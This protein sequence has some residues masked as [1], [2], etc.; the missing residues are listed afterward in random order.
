MTTVS[1]LAIDGA[2][3]MI[4]P[5][6]AI[7]YPSLFI[8]VLLNRS[9]IEHQIAGNVPAELQEISECLF[10]HSWLRGGC[11]RRMGRAQRNP[12][13]PNAGVDGFRCALPILLN[14]CPL[15][16]L[17]RLHLLCVGRCTPCL[18]IAEARRIIRTIK[19]TGGALP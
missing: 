9:R 12:S 13:A 15:R 11:L 2:A 17:R 18:R 7:T 16:D 4:A 8:P 19:N 3:M 1:A 10:R 5:S 6:A 14:A